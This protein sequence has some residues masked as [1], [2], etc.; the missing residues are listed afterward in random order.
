MLFDLVQPFLRA[1]L[2]LEIV[3]ISIHWYIVSITLFPSRIEFFTGPSSIVPSLT[4]LKACFSK[5]FKPLA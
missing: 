1:V 4:R 5:Q 3:E 2:N